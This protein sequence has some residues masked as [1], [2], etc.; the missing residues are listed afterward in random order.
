M[1]NIQ[2]Q[3]AEFMTIAGDPL[4]TLN[5]VM[6]AKEVPAKA[7]LYQNLNMEE[8]KGLED[9]FDALLI[10]D[11]PDAKL[12]A[13]AD[14]LDAICD[15][16]Y[17][18]MGLCNILGLPFQMAFD[19]VQKANMNKFVRNP[20][21]SYKVLKRADGKIVKPGNWNKPDILSILKYKLV[22]GG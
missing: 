6:K 13:L 4:L 21:G 16:I 17:T 7:I 14:V 2:S 19:E 9:A 5:D 10:A 11:L 18:R 20:D 15:S 3:V 1:A 12:A 22:I 8:D